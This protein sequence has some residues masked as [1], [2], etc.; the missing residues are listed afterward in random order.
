MTD[1]VDKNQDQEKDQDQP[2]V[3]AHEAEDLPW[4]AGDGSTC[5]SHG[6]E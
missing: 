2:E 3:I 4:C 1:P 5:G 6:L